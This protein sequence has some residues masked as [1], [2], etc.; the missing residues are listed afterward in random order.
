MKPFLLIWLGRFRREYAMGMALTTKP[1]WIDFTG[2]A[3]DVKAYR[4][5]FCTSIEPK[6]RRRS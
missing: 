4:L 1:E 5:V 6:T 3:R 2:G